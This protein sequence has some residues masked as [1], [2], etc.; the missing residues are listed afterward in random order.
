MTLNIYFDGQLVESRVVQFNNNVTQL[1]LDAFANS[2][3]D[4]IEGFE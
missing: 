3:I 4:T 1:E 2:V